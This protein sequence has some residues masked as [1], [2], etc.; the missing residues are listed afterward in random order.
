ML[1]V[2]AMLPMEDTKIIKKMSR[3]D[4]VLTAMLPQVFKTSNM[5]LC[6]K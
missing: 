5:Y 1:S 6:H 2:D 4:I 3:R